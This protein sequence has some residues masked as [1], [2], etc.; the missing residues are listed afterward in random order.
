MN[1]KQAQG[2]FVTENHYWPP[3]DLPLMPRWGINWHCRVDSIPAS[4]LY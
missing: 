3:V 4:D 2:L 1:F